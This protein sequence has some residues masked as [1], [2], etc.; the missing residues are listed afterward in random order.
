MPKRKRK[1]DAATIEHRINEGRGQGKGADY[2]PWLVIQDIPSRGLVSRVKGKKTGRIHHLFSSHEQNYFYVLDLSPSVADIREQYPLLPLEETQAIAQ[3]LGVR[4][5]TD[6]KTRSAVVMTTD[7]LVT[8]THNQE[9]ARTLKYAKELEKQRTLE[10][11][12]IERL[13]WQARETDWGIVTEQEIPD[14]LVANARLLHDYHDIADR[15]IPQAEIDRIISALQ[16]L[17]LLDTLPFEKVVSR[18]DEQLGLEVG[19]SL[20]VAYHAIATH[21]WTPDLTQPLDS[22]KPLSW[23]APLAFSEVVS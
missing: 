12:E 10:K 2:K 3:K 7:F 21:R 23:G 5:P 8:N 17:L 9:W 1:A 13:Y 14:V 6:P 16:E 22:S 19:T 11:L 20:V 18:C 15:Q 4:H